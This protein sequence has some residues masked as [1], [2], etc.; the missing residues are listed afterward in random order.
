MA[1]AVPSLAMSGPASQW[2]SITAPPPRVQPSCGSQLCA[3]WIFRGDPGQS[4]TSALTSGGKPWE[5]SR[6][7]LESQC[8]GVRNM[9]VCPDRLPQGTFP[10]LAGAQCDRRFAAASPGG[11]REL[12]V[13]S[14]EDTLQKSSF[15]NS[16]CGCEHGDSKRRSTGKASG[17]PIGQ[18][19]QGLWRWTCDTSQNT[20]VRMIS[21]PAKRLSPATNQETQG[22]KKRN[23]S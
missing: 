20:G 7:Y 22:P 14:P 3:V 13:T 15:V 2:R 11:C 12:D 8:N 6:K 9:A 23:F 19:V 16:R 21:R 17:Q 10:A 1:V 4:P 5:A 18:Q